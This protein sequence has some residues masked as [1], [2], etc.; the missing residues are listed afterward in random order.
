MDPDKQYLQ[1]FFSS[2][3]QVRMD[4]YFERLQRLTENDHLPMRIKFLIQVSM[5]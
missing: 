3:K 2:L 5:L 1:S 4:Q